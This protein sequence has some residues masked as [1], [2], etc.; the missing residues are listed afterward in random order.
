MLDFKHAIDPCRWAEE[1]LGIK[2][3]LP[4][5]RTILQSRENVLAVISR[6][7][8]KSWSAGAVAAFECLTVP[9]STVCIVSPTARQSQIMGSTIQSFLRRQKEKVEMLNESQAVLRLANGSTIHVLPGDNPDTLRGFHCELLIW[10]ET[11]FMTDDVLTAT[12]PFIT[13][14]KGRI[15]ALGTPN[16]PEGIGHSIWLEHPRGWTVLTVPADEIPEQ[17]PP[18][19]LA[20]QQM[21]MT[22]ADF[23]REYFC[24][25]DETGEGQLWSY[26]TIERCFLS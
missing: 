23:R 7:G 26:E 21:L 12:L 22:E 6:G 20:R 9:E 14:K 17:V 16:G 4:H 1:T 18:E 10:D 15:I 24:S 2:K 19:E 5:Q 3:L 11:F 25:F 8:G 13:A